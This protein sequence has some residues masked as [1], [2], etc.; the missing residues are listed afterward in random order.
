M[1]TI[2]AILTFLTT[3]FG[4]GNVWQFFTLR[5]LRRVKTAEADQ[6]SIDTLNK[7]IASWEKN[8]DSLQN[9][10]DRLN[11]KYE[12]AIAK[13]DEQQTEILA[14]RE[15]IAKLAA[16]QSKTKTKTTTKTK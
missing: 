14:I 9:R 3:L 16:K 10:Y 11:E 8:Y 6:A 5:S 12:Q 4:A 15:Q 2:E 1:N 7:V 13:I